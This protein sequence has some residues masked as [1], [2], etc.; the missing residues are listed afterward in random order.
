MPPGSGLQIRPQAPH[1][2]R[3]KECPRE[4]RPFE[5][6]DGFLLVRRMARIQEIPAAAA[7]ILIQRRIISRCL[8]DSQRGNCDIAAMIRISSAKV[9]RVRRFSTSEFARI[10]ASN[11]GYACLPDADH[12]SIGPGNGGVT[13]MPYAPALILAAPD[14]ITRHAAAMPVRAAAAERKRRRCRRRDGRNNHDTEQYSF[15]RFHECPPFCAAASSRCLG[16]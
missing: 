3:P 8:F 10:K 2:P 11:P 13:G 7:I 6:R 4:E 12:P 9:R 1:S 5:R 16:I 14:A 15:Q